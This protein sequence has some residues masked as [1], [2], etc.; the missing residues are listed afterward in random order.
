[1]WPYLLAVEDRFCADLKATTRLREQLI[2]GDKSTSNMPPKSLICPIG[3]AASNITTVRLHSRHVRNP[4][5]LSLALQKLYKDQSYTVEL[6]NDVYVI[7][8]TQP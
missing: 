4:H 5:Q 1:M 6:R 2:V 8:I 3:R 7:D